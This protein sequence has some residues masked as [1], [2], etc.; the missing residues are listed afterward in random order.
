MSGP[1]WIEVRASVPTA[2][3]DWSIFAEAFDRHGCPGSQVDD[4]TIFGYLADVA[5]AEAV[6]HA[7]TADL[8]ALGAAV[9]IG[10]IEEQD[11][12][13]LWKIHFKPRRVGKRLVLRPTWEPY[14]SEETDVEI[15][16]DPGQAFGTGDHPTTRL[17]LKLLELALEPSP[18]KTVADVGC[19]SGVLAIAAA[20]LGGKVVMA[21]DLDPISVEITR[22]N[23]RL[24]A[25]DFLTGVAGGFDA[26]S[27]PVDVAVSNIISATVIRLA[28]DAAS[29]VK[30][31][32]LWI[33]SG[34]I[35]ANWPDVEQAANRAGFTLV[36]K[37]MEDEWVGATFRH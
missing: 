26:I 16:L 3:E 5:G 1:R 18:T 17:C 23:A 21:S 34:V 12:S 32:G 9:T 25:V 35:E 22:Q 36:T 2:P 28:P 33:V 13:E 19:G 10:R 30:P 11:W 14:A 6:A 31:S 8:A 24:N 4:L 7:L 15:V 29:K 27:E 37:E 20:K